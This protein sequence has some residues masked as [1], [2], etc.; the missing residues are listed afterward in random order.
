[1]PVEVHKHC[2]REV[3]HLCQQ[4]VGWNTTIIAP[5]AVVTSV[6]PVG[7]N[8][9]VVVHDLSSTVFFRAREV[10]DLVIVLDERNI[11]TNIEV[12]STTPVASQLL[13]EVRLALEDILHFA[14]ETP[15]LQLVIRL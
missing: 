11:A 13:H 9:A 7:V 1:V 5:I 14:E 6:L 10:I 8:H 15:V 4:H 2:V 3:G 12:A